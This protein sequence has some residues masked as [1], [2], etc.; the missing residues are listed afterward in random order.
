MKLTSEN[1]KNFKII[2]TL[3]KYDLICFLNKLSELTII[4]AICWCIIYPLLYSFVQS[5]ILFI[6]LVT[7]AFRLLLYC[8]EAMM[9]L[10]Y[11][12]FFKNTEYLIDNIEID[13]ITCRYLTLSWNR[14]RINKTIEIWDNK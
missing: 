13:L 1:F 9:Y 12:L 14:N 11:K 2:P 8:T 10:A 6:N 3:F 4:G 5:I 7:L